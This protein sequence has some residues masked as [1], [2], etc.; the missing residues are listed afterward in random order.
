MK[1]SSN[2]TLSPL[3]RLPQTSDGD[4]KIE[5]SSAPSTS[6]PQPTTDA[7]VKVTLTHD[8]AADSDNLYSKPS[9]VPA[10]MQINYYSF[11]DQTSL[12]SPSGPTR[13]EY[14]VYRPDGVAIDSGTQPFT[15]KSTGEKLTDAVAQ[16]I[17]AMLLDVTKHR[18][19]IYEAGEKD[20]LSSSEI[21]ARLQAYDRSLPA[22]YHALV[23]DST[24]TNPITRYGEATHDEA[25]GG[26][27]QTV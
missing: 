20:G 10:V 22:S 19:A 16:K 21:I 9:N 6:I 12:G 8:R 2:S 23:G 17:Q 14:N 5:S 11:G 4:P 15:V 3:T 27:P 18:I 26:P 1:L 7:G 25:M 13:L 24:M